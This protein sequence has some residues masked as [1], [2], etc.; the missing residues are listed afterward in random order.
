MAASVLG[1]S[2]KGSPCLNDA[3]QSFPAPD[4]RRIMVAW[5]NEWEWMPFFK[6]WGPTY[7]EGWC[8]FFNFPREVKYDQKWK[9]EFCPDT[10][11]K[12]I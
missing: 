5:A 2:R 10:G 7:R 12:K 4:G 8:G 3:P 9:I 6:N 1:K 11:V